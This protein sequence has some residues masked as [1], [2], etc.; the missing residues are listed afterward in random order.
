M[1]LVP[2]STRLLAVLFLYSLPVVLSPRQ[3]PDSTFFRQD[4]LFP[5]LICRRPALCR[6]RCTRHL[7]PPRAWPPLIPATGASICF[8]LSILAWV[9]TSPP[10][11]RVSALGYS[12]PILN[13]YMTESSPASAT[14]TARSARGARRGGGGAGAERHA[15]QPAEILVDGAAYPGASAPA[16]EA[17][18]SSMLSSMPAA[19]RGLYTRT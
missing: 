5:N 11:R 4:R 12:C 15:H 3:V 1:L 16:A 13:A 14:I 10:R 8:S 17:W 19:S 18:R 6:S 9:A 2:F 7:P